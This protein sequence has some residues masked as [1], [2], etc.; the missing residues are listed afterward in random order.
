MST[1][2]LTLSER[3]ATL[4][5]TTRKMEREWVGVFTSHTDQIA[6]LNQRFLVHERE[7]GKTSPRK[8]FFVLTRMAYRQLQANPISFCLVVV[9][10]TYI[11]GRVLGIVNF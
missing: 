1:K 6:E 2:K 5:G 3:V 10:A 7:H 11:C 8:R 9:A 4:E